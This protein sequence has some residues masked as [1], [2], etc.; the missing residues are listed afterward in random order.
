MFQLPFQ[1][2]LSCVLLQRHFGMA[3][4]HGERK[5]FSMLAPDHARICVLFLQRTP[6]LCL[7]LVLQL[8]DYEGKQL[9]S[10]IC[11]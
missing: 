2:V 4:M 10:S 7:S 11:M 5:T 1:A 6:S 8:G 9:E 3:A